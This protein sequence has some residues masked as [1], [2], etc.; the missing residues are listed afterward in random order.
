MSSG[1][2][3]CRGQYRIKEVTATHLFEPGEEAHVVS[4]WWNGRYTDPLLSRVGVTQDRLYP[5]R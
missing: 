3:Y 1:F 5:D 4:E 2:F